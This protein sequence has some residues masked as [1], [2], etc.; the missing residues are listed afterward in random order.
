[1]KLARQKLPKYRW[2]VVSSE[3][4]TPD[5]CAALDEAGAEYTTYPELLH[6]LVPLDSYVEGLITD[7]ETWVSN[8]WGGEDWFI[9]PYVKTDVTDERYLALA[10]F[11]KWLGDS[12]AN[13]LTI[14]GDLGT[15]KSTLASFLAYNLACSFRDDPLRHPA[16]V[17]IP[18]K[19]VHKEVSLEGI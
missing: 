11:A 17:L 4:F 3:G 10:Y 12:R 18:L 19:E 16:P 2:L 1:H 6:D 8:N 13:Q 5:T 9:R 15:G 7:Y 14:L